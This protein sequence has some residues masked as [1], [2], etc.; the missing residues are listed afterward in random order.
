[1]TG[2]DPIE[3]EHEGHIVSLHPAEC[4]TLLRGRTLGRVAVKLTDD[5]VILPVYYGISTTTSSSER[6][7]GPNSTRRC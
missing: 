2:V 4:Y 5:I 1:M 7:R 3:T 6:P